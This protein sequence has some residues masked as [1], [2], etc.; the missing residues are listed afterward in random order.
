MSNQAITLFAV[1]GVVLV[2]SLFLIESP[3]LSIALVVSVAF[4]LGGLLSQLATLTDVMRDITK[5]RNR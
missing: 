5:R 4:M 2:F 3:L 1:G